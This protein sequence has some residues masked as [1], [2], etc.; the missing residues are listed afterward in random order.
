MDIYRLETLDDLYSVG[1]GEY[2]DGRN[3]LVIEWAEKLEELKDLPGRLFRVVLRREDAVSPSRR[4]ISIRVQEAG[5][6]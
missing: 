4:V 3:I 1:F 2:Y 6:C 5:Q